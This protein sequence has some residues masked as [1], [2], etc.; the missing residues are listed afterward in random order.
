MVQRQGQPKFRRELLKAYGRRCAITEC[1]AVEALEAAHIIGYLGSKT[2]HPTNGLLLRADLHS[3]FDLSL[4][5]VDSVT[6]TVLIAPSLI[7][8]VYVELAGKQVRLPDDPT[9]KPSRE[10]IDQHREQAGL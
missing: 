3:L 4:I 2:N 5:A 10:A 7:K 6:M 9:C 1:D 8:T